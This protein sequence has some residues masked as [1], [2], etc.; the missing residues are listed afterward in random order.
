[1]DLL[2]TIVNL[3]GAP[4]PKNK[5][6]GLSFMPLL[7]GKAS[8]GP[9]EVFYHYYDQNSLKAVRYKNWKLV[10]PHQ[11]RSY[12]LDMP[13]KEG[14]PGKTTN[15]E[16]KQALYN[17]THDPG[18]VYDVQKLYPEIAENI[19]AF[20]EQAREDLGDDL[21]KRKGKNVRSPAQLQ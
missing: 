20:V 8:K 10:L 14:Y 16:V 12:V 11:S 1:M 19:M 3:T 6:D 4:S 7:L 13:G 5:I 15:V 2:P 21:T 9:R 18:E 17:L